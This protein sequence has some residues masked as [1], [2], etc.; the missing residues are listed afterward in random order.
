MRH[1]YSHRHYDNIQNNGFQG[2]Q[3]VSPSG[4]FLYGSYEKH[5][6]CLFLHNVKGEEG[7]REGGRGGEEKEGGGNGVM[8][9]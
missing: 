6:P 2:V 5:Q 8:S 4:C 1:V 7:G 3:T 9:R